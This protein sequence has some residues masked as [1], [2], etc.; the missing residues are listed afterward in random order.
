VAGHVRVAFGVPDAAAATA[1]LTSAG[2]VLI[3]PPTRTPWNSLNSR[4]NG[5]A[6]LQLTLFQDLGG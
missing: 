4:L 2:A 6:G 3:A 1:K 5:P